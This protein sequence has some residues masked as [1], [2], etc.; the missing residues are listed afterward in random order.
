MDASP[1]RDEFERCAPADP[2]GP[3]F[4]A[5]AGPVDSYPSAESIEDGCALHSHI[6]VPLLRSVV[7]FCRDLWHTFGM[8]VAFTFHP[9]QAVSLH[10]GAPFNGEVTA[11][12][13]AGND[14]ATMEIGVEDGRPVINVLTFT[15]A[16]DPETG[17]WPVGPPVTPAFVRKFPTKEVFDDVVKRVAEQAAF[18]ADRTRASRLALGST[19]YRRIDGEL[20][21]D[22]LAVIEEERAAAEQERRRPKQREAVAEAFACSDRTASRY[23]KA[24]LDFEATQQQEED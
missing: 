24:A 22:V 2:Q 12:I 16:Q 8:D 18:P 6:V 21:R 11:F 10:N 3:G 14:L 23:I 4:P 19:K 1:L 15:R 5:D 9:S 7:A 20:C 17:N 13:R